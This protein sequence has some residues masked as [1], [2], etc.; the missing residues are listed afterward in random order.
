MFAVAAIVGHDVGFVAG[1]A[2]FVF[3]DHHLPVA[4]AFDEDDVIAGVLEGVGRGQRHGGAHAAGED[5][6]GAVVLDFGGLAERA[7]DVEDG[8]AGFKGVEQRGGFADGLD[9]DGDGAGVGIGALMVSGMRSPCSWRRRIR[10]W[11]GF[12]LR[13]MRGASMT[14]CLMLRPTVRASTILN[15]Q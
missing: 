7:D 2:D 4:R 1:R 9:D 15:M 12:C 14:N 8:V 13:A 11:P 6:G 10:N 3:K 5:D